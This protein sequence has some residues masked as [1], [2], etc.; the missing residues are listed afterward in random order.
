MKIIIHECRMPLFSFFCFILSLACKMNA[1][2]LVSNGVDDTPIP[3]VSFCACVKPVT[4]TAQPKQTRW[5]FG[6]VCCCSYGASFTCWL[7][8]T[9]LIIQTAFFVVRTMLRYVGDGGVGAYGT[10]LGTVFCC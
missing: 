2:D 10:V 7:F 4:T 5:L 9:V 3:F 8:G 6:T 1:L